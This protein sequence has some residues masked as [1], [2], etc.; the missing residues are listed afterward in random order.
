M[1]EECDV[2]YTSLENVR[3]DPCLVKT[4]QGTNSFLPEYFC[5]E[6]VLAELFQTSA[7]NIYITLVLNTELKVIACGE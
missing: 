7:R 5:S 1:E 4:G 6:N 2:L 3:R